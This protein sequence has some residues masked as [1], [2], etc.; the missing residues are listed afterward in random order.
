MNV[1]LGRWTVIGLRVLT[2]ELP[3]RLFKEESVRKDGTEGEDS[4]MLT[5]AETRD[6]RLESNFHTPHTM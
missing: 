2:R 3:C 4:E 1:E 5:N 6:H